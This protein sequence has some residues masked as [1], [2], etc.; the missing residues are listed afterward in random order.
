ML[1]YTLANLL[2]CLGIHQY[3]ISGVLAEPI[4]TILIV[5]NMATF[6]SGQPIPADH[7]MNMQIINSFALIGD[8]GCTLMLLFD[9][10]VFSKSKTSRAVAKMAIVPGLFN[11]NEPVIYGYPIVYNLPLII[12]FVI[13]R[14]LQRRYLRSH[15]RRHHRSV[16]SAGALDHASGDLCA[17]GD[18]H[19]LARRRGPYRPIAERNVMRE[20]LIYNP[21]LYHIRPFQLER[22]LAIAHA[23]EEARAGGVVFYGDSLTEF[24]HVAR[25]F[26]ALAANGGPGVYNAGIGGTTTEELLWYVDEAVINTVRGRWCSWPAPMTSAARCRGRPRPRPRTCVVWS[27]SLWATCPPAACSSGRPCRAARRST[28]RPPSR[29]WCALTPCCAR[30]SPARRRG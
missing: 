29:A 2:F 21:H 25:C 26:P 8:S 7:Y 5:D 11:I 20:D 9:T 27:T 18:R 14:P 19:G 23:R 10:L 3:T 15:L 28:A 17:S 22:M 6:T 30:Y 4:L 13:M 24:Y 12:P 1:I 16:R